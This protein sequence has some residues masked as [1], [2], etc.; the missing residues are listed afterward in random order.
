MAGR[1]DLFVRTRRE[2]AYGIV[3]SVASAIP[4]LMVAL[5]RA[6]VKNTNTE[7]L[8]LR[9]AEFL[10]W[11]NRLPDP[12]ALKEAASLRGLN[13]GP[14]AVPLSPELQRTVHEFREWFQDWLPTV[15][16]ESKPT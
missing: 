13:L 8:E 3:S 14:H 11:T 15:L 6:V 10:A 2:G 5:G 4:E 9:V 16:D 1:D 7:P 12:I